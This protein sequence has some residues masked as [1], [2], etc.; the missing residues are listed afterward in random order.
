M[1]DYLL[2][3]ADKNIDLSKQRKQILEDGRFLYNYY[4]A[5][6]NIDNDYIIDN[7]IIYVK[8]P[9]NY[10]Y[11]SMLFYKAISYVYNNINNIKGVFKFDSDLEL[12]IDNLYK[13][14]NNNKYKYFGEVY[15]NNIHYSNYHTKFFN[16]K[17]LLL[18]ECIYCSCVGYYLSYD[19][20]KHLI[21][22]KNIFELIIYEDICV[23]VILNRNNIYPQ[24]IN[25]LNEIC[26]EIEEE[27]KQIMQTNIKIDNNLCKYCGYPMNKVK[28]NYC[29]NCQKIY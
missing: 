24:Y 10:E 15:K 27:K 8:I 13:A 5:D 23:G 28:Y 19:I 14:T 4:I 2:I 17:D 22:N 7:D 26:K 16:E 18:P 11:I 20:L 29:P 1:K 9:N 25:I 3:L 12:N 21:F 6:P